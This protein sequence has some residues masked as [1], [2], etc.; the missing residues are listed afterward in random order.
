MFSD[1]CLPLKIW[2]LVIGLM[3]RISPW[4]LQFLKRPLSCV[5]RRLSSSNKNCENRGLLRIS[6]GW[7]SKWI[8]FTMIFTEWIH[9]IFTESTKTFIKCKKTLFKLSKIVV[10][11]KFHEDAWQNTNE[12]SKRPWNIL[13]AFSIE[14]NVKIICFYSLFLL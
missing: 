7:L 12:A 3:L 9:M 14:P 8:N 5:Q 4:F 13:V 1:N 10:Y 2:I 11:L 6:W